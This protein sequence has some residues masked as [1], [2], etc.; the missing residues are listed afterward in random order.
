MKK[1]SKKWNGSTMDIT[2]TEG[3]TAWQFVAC[4]HEETNAWNTFGYIYTEDGEDNLTEFRKD[5]VSDDE[6]GEMISRFEQE[7]GPKIAR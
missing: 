5:S 4:F 6:V 2:V 3:N 7:Y 1:M